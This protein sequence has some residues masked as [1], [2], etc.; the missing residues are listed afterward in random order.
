VLFEG[1]FEPAERLLLLP[2]SGVDD[3]EVVRRDV[4]APRQPV[5]FA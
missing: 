1:A 2:E 5:Q 3:G 4:A